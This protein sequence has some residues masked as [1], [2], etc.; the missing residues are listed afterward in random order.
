MP[1]FFL[2]LQRIVKRDCGRAGMRY[3]VGGRRYKVKFAGA[4]KRLLQKHMSGTIGRANYHSYLIPY[5]LYLRDEVTES[6]R[7]VAGI[8]GDT[9]LLGDFGN[10]FGNGDGNTLVEG[11]GD[12]IVFVQFIVGAEGGHGFG[13]G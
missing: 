13:R 5:H 3:E 8:A 1:G 2:F 12:D 11:T 6:E 10:L 9:E 4:G 7:S